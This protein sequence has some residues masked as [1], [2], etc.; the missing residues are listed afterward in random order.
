MMLVMVLQLLGPVLKEQSSIIVCTLL[1]M[2]FSHI[3]YNIQKYSKA[4]LHTA[5]KQFVSVRASCCVL[6]LVELL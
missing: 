6:Y 3:A 5:S 1:V 2:P 4:L